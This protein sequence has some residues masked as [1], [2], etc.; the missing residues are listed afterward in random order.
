VEVAVVDGG[1]RRLVRL[2]MSVNTGGE[3]A[4]KLTDSEKQK[5]RE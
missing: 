1:N 5:R 3:M 2:P 4:G